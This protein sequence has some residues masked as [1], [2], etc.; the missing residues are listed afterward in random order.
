M[1][2]SG[3][4]FLVFLG[5]GIVG[6]ALLGG[7]TLVNNAVFFAGV[8]VATASLFA[9][10]RLS[11]GPPTRVQL[12]AL[13]GAI[14]LEVV[15]MMAMGRMLAPG[16]EKHW[17]WALVIVGL[18]FIPMALAFGPRMLVLGLVCMANAGLGLAAASMPF[19][20][21]G[22][23]DGALKVAFG[24]WMLLTKER[25]APLRSTP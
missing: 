5:L 16:L 14:L 18:H 19:L 15:L 25:G 4:L 9:A 22:L 12:I 6:G 20:V 7:D 23:V 11:Y 24:G 17:L 13:G 10:R 1:V 3:G 21:I 8:G 2:R